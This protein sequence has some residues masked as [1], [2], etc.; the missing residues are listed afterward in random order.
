[1]TFDFEGRNFDTPTVESA[2][3]W[4]EQVL[5]SF[6]GHLL[7][8]LLVVFGPRLSFVQRMVEQ[9]AAR[10]AEI[11][12]AQEQ[13]QIALLQPSDENETFVF[14]APLVETA[15]ETAPR[16][17]AVASDRDRV[18][19]SPVLTPDS[20]RPLPVAEGNTDRFVQFGQSDRR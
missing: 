12:A 20:T 18:A 5:V 16:P 3:S 19:Q 8:V 4:R 14:V 1:M 15:P 9:R 11:Q 6:F 17:D 10:L 13:A 7:L 2:I